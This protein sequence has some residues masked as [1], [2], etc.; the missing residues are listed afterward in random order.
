MMDLIQR[1]FSREKTNRTETRKNF[2]VYFFAQPEHQ[3][4]TNSSSKVHFEKLITLLPSS[5]LEALMTKYP[6]TF[7]P[8]YAM[9][10]KSPGTVMTNTIVVFP[11]FQ[12]LLLSDRPSALAYIAHELA[13]VLWEFEGKK[14][15]SDP[16]MAEIAADKFVVDLGL[17]FEL[18]ELL[19][20]LDET[21]EKRLRLTYLTINHFSG[22]NN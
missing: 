4:I 16:L 7:V 14:P 1:F 10:G 3:W 8:S 20:M 9:K 12:K 22:H 6:I 18:E 21:I 2:S 15:D 5:L 19:L 11:E 17:T 13:F